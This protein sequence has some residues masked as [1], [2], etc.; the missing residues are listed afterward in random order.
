MRTEELGVCEC[1]VQTL[2]GFCH[3]NAIERID[4]LKIDVEGGELDVLRGSRQMLEQRRIGLVYVECHQLCSA[5]SFSTTQGH[6]A[7]AELDA[8]LSP[9]GYRFVTLYTES[10]HL[11]ECIG[12]YNALFA[13]NDLSQ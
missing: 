3:E 5:V 11:D 12:T 2:D 1:R 10:V 4:L 9:F 8:F 6:T 7:L 13:H